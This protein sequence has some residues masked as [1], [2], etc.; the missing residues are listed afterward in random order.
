MKIKN[1]KLV[2]T[3]ITFDATPK[4]SGEYK[5]GSPDTIIIHYTAGNSTKTAVN[6]LKNPRIRASAH[7]VI[8]R[9]GK[10]VQLADLNVI[11]WHAGNSSYTFPDKKRTTFN[12]YS[13]GIEIA[14]DGFLIK[15]NGKFY[16]WY[17]KEVAEEFVYEGKH[18]NYPQT[19]SKYWHTFTNVQV[20]KVYD[21]CKEIIK[22]YPTIKYILERNQ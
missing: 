16:N 2:G 1:H 13:I 6:V 4:T 17:K 9:D 5:K 8:G 22:E 14:N 15:K 7:M 21:I 12:K 20:K 3:G 18:R 19:R 10:I 11:T